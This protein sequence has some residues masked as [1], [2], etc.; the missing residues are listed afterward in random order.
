MR[1]ELIEDLSAMEE[2]MMKTADR[3]D[4]WQDRLIYAICKAVYH[5]IL[6]VLRM[7]R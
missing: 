2:G 3:S 7:E 1:R 6:W 5:L 4:I